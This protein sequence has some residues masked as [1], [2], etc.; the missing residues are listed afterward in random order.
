M[1]FDNYT[2]FGIKDVSNE[3]RFVE[4]VILFSIIGSIL[5]GAVIAYILNCVD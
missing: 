2:Y 1:D 5:I 4:R 3:V